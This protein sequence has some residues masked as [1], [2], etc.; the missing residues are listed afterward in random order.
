VHR[1]GLA[2]LMHMPERL[3]GTLAFGLVTA[4]YVMPG[5][6]PSRTFSGTDCHIIK[7][8]AVRRFCRSAY[9]ISMSVLEKVREGQCLFSLL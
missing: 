3:R 8:L 5:M 7:R 2:D 1:L 9:D 4:S 6:A